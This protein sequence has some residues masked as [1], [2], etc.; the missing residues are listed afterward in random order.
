MDAVQYLRKV[1]YFT[2][3]GML[4]ADGHRE[5]QHDDPERAV[6]AVEKLYEKNFLTDCPYCYNFFNP[7]RIGYCE[8]VVSDHFEISVTGTDDS[9]PMKIDCK[10]EAILDENGFLILSAFPATSDY[11]PFLAKKRIMFCPMCGQKLE[12]EGCK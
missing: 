8:T 12:R 11:V 6:E 4:D 3:K 9:L 2:K 5:L 1:D 7:N 10:A